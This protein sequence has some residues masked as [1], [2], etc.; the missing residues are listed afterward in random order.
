MTTMS[1]ADLYAQA[2][3]EGALFG[4]LP[5]GGPYTARIKNTNMKPTQNGKPRLGFHFEIIEGPQS[6]QAGWMNQVISRENPKAMGV[7]FSILGK[8][9][10]TPAHLDQL[11]EE[12]A[13]AIARGQV[14]VITVEHVQGGQRPGGGTYTNVN[15]R[16]QQRREDLEGAAAPAAP[17]PP[18][19]VPAAPAPVPE[20]PAP[21]APAPAP[22]APAPA[23]P[24]P[25]PE[26]PAPAPAPVAAPPAAVEQPM[27]RPW[28]PPAQS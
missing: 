13:A 23:A 1:Y 25:V 8:M 4:E 27:Q 6:G 21:A 28:D 22:A 18:A 5:A 12:G 16:L 26:A 19:P 20:A 11:G 7:L 24:A 17:A 9:G 2:E 14:W 15:V 3:A 10:I